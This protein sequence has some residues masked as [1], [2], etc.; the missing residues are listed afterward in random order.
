MHEPMDA[1]TTATRLRRARLAAGLQLSDIEQ[2]TRISPSIL[3]WID[4]GQFHRLPAGIYARSYVRA[5]AQAVGL[6]PNEIVASV[7]HELPAAAE[8]TPPSESKAPAPIRQL[9]PEWLRVA[10]ASLDAAV[11]TIIYGLVLGVTAAVCRRPVSEILAFGMPAMIVLLTVLTALYFLIFAGVQG[12]TPGARAFG[13]PPFQV[14]GPM[15]LRTIVERALRVFVCEASLGVEIA[16]RR[17]A[18]REVSTAAPYGSSST[19]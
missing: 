13:L 6:D 11:L 15:R 9:S 19:P 7:E 3:R 16:S 12:Q 14:S 18:P 5:F 1:P 10:A 17:S 4:N 8:L 2:R